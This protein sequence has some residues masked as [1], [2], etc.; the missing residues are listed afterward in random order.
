MKVIFRK[1]DGR[2]LGAQAVGRDGVDKRIDALAVAIQLGGTIHDLEEAELCYAP[3]FGSAKSPANFAGMVAGDVLAG[4]MPVAHWGDLD[5]E[6]LLD[7]RHPEELAAEALPGVVN[8]PVD[9]LRVAAGRA[10]ARPRDRRHL[11]FGPA[12]LLR[13]AHPAAERLQ[14]SCHVRRHA[15][16]RDLLGGVTRAPSAATGG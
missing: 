8:I 12:R 5:G 9:Q 15:L 4:D 7:V 2:L 16:P 10:A 3:Q 6:F 13:D 11:P 14:G 1:S